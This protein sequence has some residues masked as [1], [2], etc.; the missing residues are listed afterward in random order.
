MFF[1]EINNIIKIC[2]LLESCGNKMV[3][4]LL[5]KFIL[6]NVKFNSLKKF[7][8]SKFTEPP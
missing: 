3:S 5:L 8:H 4:I 2:E 1:V 6:K 7:T